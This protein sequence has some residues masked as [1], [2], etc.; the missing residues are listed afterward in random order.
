MKKIDKNLIFNE[1]SASRSKPNKTREN[2]AGKKPSKVKSKSKSLTNEDHNLNVYPHFEKLFIMRPPQRGS[3]SNIETNQCLCDLVLI[4]N[5]NESQ[6]QK[7]T[8]IEN[9]KKR[10][11]SQKSPMETK[12]SETRKSK[13]EF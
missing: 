13:I 3:H 12:S 11:S 1:L 8:V 9:R 2:S 5:R 4:P 10:P 6:F 7:Q